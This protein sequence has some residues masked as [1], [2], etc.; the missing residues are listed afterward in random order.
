MNS[1]QNQT[2]EIFSFHYLNIPFYKIPYY[3]FFKRSFKKLKGLNH[4]EFLIPMQLGEPLF[5][6]RR[7]RLTEIAF[8]AFWETEENLNQFLSSSISK[9]FQTGWY[10]RLRLYRKWGEIS[11]IVSATLYNRNSKNENTTV[12]I[13]LARLKLTQLFRFT[14]WGKPVETQVRNHP[15]K[16]IAFA[17]FRPPRHFLTFS[18]WDSEANMIQ[19]VT[20]KDPNQDGLQH[21][22]AMLERNRKDFHFEF[23]TLRFELLGKHGLENI[24]KSI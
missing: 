22:E 13:T 14:K 15:G 11:E 23:T 16:Q 20:G 24:N 10:V 21:K 2:Q 1:I 7:Y 4:C 8:L 18:I 3:L 6:L 17:A 5:G 12:A 19:M 9:S